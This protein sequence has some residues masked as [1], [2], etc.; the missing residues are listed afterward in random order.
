[1][2]CQLRPDLC[3]VAVDVSFRHIALRDGHLLNFLP[4]LLEGF[5]PL[6]V[7]DQGVERFELRR[8]G[9]I[10]DTAPDELV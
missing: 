1:M 4:Q 9:R 3:Y 10:F 2:L 8:G 7:R 6:L 5:L